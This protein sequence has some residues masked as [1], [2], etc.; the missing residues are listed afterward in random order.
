MPVYVCE[1]ER[2]V[3]MCG[4]ERGREG[5]STYKKPAKWRVNDCCVLKDPPRKV[6]TTANTILLLAFTAVR[7]GTGDS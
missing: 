1:R 5:E 7:R 4:E 2:G 3:C 6:L